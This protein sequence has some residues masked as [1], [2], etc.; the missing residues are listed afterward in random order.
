MSRPS[1]EKIREA[2]DA[3]NH[4]QSNLEVARSIVIELHDKTKDVVDAEYMVEHQHR[5]SEPSDDRNEV[6]FA[7]LQTTKESLTLLY[8]DKITE[9][10]HAYL[11]HIIK[12]A[13]DAKKL[14]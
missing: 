12:A 3:I 2:F 6:L 14:L 10:I 8:D 5:W 11:D 1:Q 4:I 9:G 13:Q 7:R